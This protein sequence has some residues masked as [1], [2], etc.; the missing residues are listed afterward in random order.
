MCFQN[1]IFFALW[2]AFWDFWP[3]C[4]ITK[5]FCFAKYC[6]MIKAECGSALSCCKIHELSLQSSGRFLRIASHVNCV[7]LF[8][9]TLYWLYGL[10][11]GIHDKQ[12]HCSWRKRLTG[13]SHLTGLDVVF[14]VFA[15]HKTSIGT[16]GPSFH[17]RSHIPTFFCW[18]F[19]SFGTNLAAT[20]FMFKPLV[21]TALHEP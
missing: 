21:K 7:K 6:W 17:W 2:L 4:R 18:Q 16:I 13:P 3:L 5:V 14:P 8:D 12:L 9:S 11:V 15:P 19:K 20:H 10:V 1:I